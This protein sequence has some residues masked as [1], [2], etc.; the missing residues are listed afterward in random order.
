MVR[1]KK[2]DEFERGILHKQ[3]SFSN[4]NERKIAFVKVPKYV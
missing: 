2:G 4:I 1:A 3:T